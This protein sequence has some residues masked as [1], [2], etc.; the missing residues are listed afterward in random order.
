[1]EIMTSLLGVVAG[2]FTGA[3][4]IITPVKVDVDVD[5]TVNVYVDKQEPNWL[6]ERRKNEVST[7]HLG[8]RW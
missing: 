8:K 7:S 2:L 1:M 4:D 5:V 3:T 6:R